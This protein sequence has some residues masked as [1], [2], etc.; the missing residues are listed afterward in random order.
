MIP[1]KYLMPSSILITVI[2]GIL[3]L[4][5]LEISLLVIFSP[6]IGLGVGFLTALC[7]FLFICLVEYIE[8]FILKQRRS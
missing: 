4:T 2:L 7:T 5:G 1:V 3:K 8:D 6:I